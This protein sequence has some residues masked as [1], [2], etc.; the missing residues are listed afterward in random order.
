[1]YIYPGAITST[2]Y[3]H[4]SLN[5][6]SLSFPLSSSR[7]FLPKPNYGDLWSPGSLSPSYSEGITCRT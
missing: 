2:T 5:S 7:P 3:R 1:M 6:A 4:L